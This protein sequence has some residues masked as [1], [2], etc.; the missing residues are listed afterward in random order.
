MQ[1][2]LKEHEGVAKA[3]EALAP[4][5]AAFVEVDALAGSTR[6]DTPEAAAAVAAGGPGAAGGGGGGGGSAPPA[7]PACAPMETLLQLQHDFRSAALANAQ[8]LLPCECFARLLVFSASLDTPSAT[9]A[10]LL[11]SPSR[12]PDSS[13]SILPQPGA[14]L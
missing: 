11:E 1:E 13:P 4:G 9:L 7:A 14:H 10:S 2:A 8:A 3:L 6:L 12:L 5:P